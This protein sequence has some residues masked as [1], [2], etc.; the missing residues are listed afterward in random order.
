MKERC[1]EVLWTSVVEKRGQRPPAPYFP[2]KTV[3]FNDVQACFYI[4]SRVY[5]F[6]ESCNSFSFSW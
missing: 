4:S 5:F 2:E 1:G 6:A 3:F